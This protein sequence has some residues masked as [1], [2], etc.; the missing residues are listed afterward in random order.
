MKREKSLLLIVFLFLLSLI[1]QNAYSKEKEDLN[2]PKGFLWGTATSAYQVEGGIKN[3]WS[4]NGLDAGKAANHFEEFDN[5][6]KIAKSLGNNAYRMSIEWARIEPEKDQW[7]Q[8]GVDFYKKIFKSLKK[9]GLKPMVTIHHFTN[10]IWTEKFGGWEN[11]EIIER[12]AKFTTFL[13]KTFGDDVDLWLTF[14]EPNVYALKSFATGDWPPFKKDRQITLY[15][16]N[17]ILK[18]HAE[19]YRIL[20]EFDNTDADSD[21]IACEVGFA[22]HIA[23]LEPFWVLNPLDHLM[24]YFQNKV[25]NEAFWDACTTGKFDLF[26]PGLKSIDEPFNEKLK[27]SMDFV[28]FNYYT[29]WFIKANGDNVPNEKGE[30]TDMKWEIY[31]T[32]LG[33]SIQLA[34]NYAKKRNLPIYITEVGL[35][36]PNDSKRGK[37]IVTHTKS[38]LDEIK[39]GS[40]VKGFMFWSLM[41]NF[42]LADGYGPKFG[43]M[44]IDRKIKQSAYVYKEIA[45]TNSIPEKLS[46]KYLK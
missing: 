25:F 38:M 16:M 31:P 37:Y 3:D 4:K 45:E 13:A 17:N 43:L 1:N 12:F 14:N 36:D 32:G 28:G 2:F 44:T 5:D 19:A 26:I 46:E 30:L 6:F 33:K 9:H 27:N 10:P 11:K 7:S 34:N 22:Q 24:T 29:R 41:D 21:G 35:S 15:V 42:E 18:A 39:K 40:N 20:H 23:V 8:E